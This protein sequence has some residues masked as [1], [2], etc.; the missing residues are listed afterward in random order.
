MSSSMFL[1]YTLSNI[2]ISLLNLWYFSKIINYWTS[3]S[4]MKLLRK[5]EIFSQ[6]IKILNY[7]FALFNIFSN[8]LQSILYIKQNIPL[9]IFGFKS[10]TLIISYNSNHMVLTYN[11]MEFSKFISKK[12]LKDHKFEITKWSKAKSSSKFIQLLFYNQII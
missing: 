3:N 1:L 6:I 10:W 7:S 4:I 9:N 8:K 2:L 11:F 12:I 5:T